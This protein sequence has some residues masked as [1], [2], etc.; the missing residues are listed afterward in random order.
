MRGK[1]SCF[2][3][4]PRVIPLVMLGGLAVAA[5]AGDDGDDAE[6]SGTTA[7][8]ST[9]APS[10]TGDGPM[11]TSADGSSGAPTT[12]GDSGGTGDPQDGSLGDQHG[13]ILLE[14]Q[15]PEGVA[16]DPFVGTARVSVTMSYLE[17]LVAF[18]DT[19]PAWWQDGVDGAVIFETAAGPAGLCSKDPP[20]APC[21]V[22]AINQNVDVAQAINIEYTVSGGLEG[23]T[24]RVGP[25][26]TAALAACAPGT[27]PALRIG[28]G[29]AIRGL[30]AGGAVLWEALSFAPD[31]AATDDGTAIVIRAGTP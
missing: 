20:S 29:G 5:C 24:L 26:P 3:A 1:I 22:L 28:G 17:C 8:G 25:V 9:G 14:F 19:N 13:V 4:I 21:T 12:A 31:Q 30:D 6:P 18:Y 11:G 23:Q 7:A 27:S 16:E 15:R 10:S 2:L